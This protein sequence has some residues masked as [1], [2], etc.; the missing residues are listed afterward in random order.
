MKTITI[1]RPSG[2]NI[3]SIIDP[4]TTEIEQMPDHRF[5]TPYERDTSCPKELHDQIQFLV[6]KIRR[7]VGRGR[8]TIVEAYDED[9]LFIEEVNQVPSDFKMSDLLHLRGDKAYSRVHDSRHKPGVKE[10]HGCVDVSPRS[11]LSY[12]F[13]GMKGAEEFPA[14]ADEESYAQY[15]LQLVNSMSGTEGHQFMR[16]TSFVDKEGV[17]RG[18][19]ILFLVPTGGL[20]YPEIAR[21]Y[22]ETKEEQRLF[23]ESHEAL[24]RKNIRH[25]SEPRRKI[26]F[27]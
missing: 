16:M 11:V 21:R 5:H 13:T 23:D 12:A 25:E 10:H 14:L 4:P 24:I 18:V 1:A 9:N 8:D 26:N 27:C 15:R 22:L 7:V 17:H 2:E 3:K 6:E 19:P 20:Y